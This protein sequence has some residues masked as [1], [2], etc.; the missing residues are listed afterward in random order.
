MSNE[1]GPITG[2][3]PQ[4]DV[5]ASI[6]TQ[7][8]ALEKAG[9]EEKENDDQSTQDTSSNTKGS[10]STSPGSSSSSASSPMSSSGSS[11]SSVK[12]TASQSSSQTS[13]AASSCP[14]YVYPDDDIE[15]WEGTS[16]NKR[17]I[18]VGGRPYKESQD[19]GG[20]NRKTEESLHRQHELRKRDPSSITKINTCTFPD[21]G[22]AV[23]PGYS[24]LKGF[25]AL[26]K[27]MTGQGGRN[28]IVYNAA[29]KWYVGIKDCSSPSGFSAYK[30]ADGVEPPTDIPKESQQS[31][32]HVC[33]S[34]LIP[35][36]LLCKLTRR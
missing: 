35:T 8:D 24:Q 18:D 22:Q 1:V 6:S 17:A 30:T 36:Y 15:E 27:Q 16:N 29:S 12:S 25:K 23:Q 34:Y 3:P 9:E 5:I 26:Y 7:L 10:T 32:D 11:A 4:S 33:E 20:D 21:K 14:S 31:I 28:G 2:P 19:I 13:S